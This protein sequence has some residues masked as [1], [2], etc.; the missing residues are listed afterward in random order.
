MTADLTT[1]YDAEMATSLAEKIRNVSEDSEQ[2]RRL[3]KQ[4][5]G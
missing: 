5:I 2:L 3:G 4:R 1:N